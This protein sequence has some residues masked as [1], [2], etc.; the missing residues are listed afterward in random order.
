M[1]HRS[2]SFIVTLVLA[3][4]FLT[5][6]SKPDLYDSEGGGISLKDDSGKWL[7]LNIWAE[8]CDPCRDEVPELNE[9]ADSGTVR[10]LG[11]DFDN[12]QGDELKKKIKALDIRFPVVSSS[13]LNLL[14]TQVPAVLPAT[15]IV[16]AQGKLV[17]VLYGPQTQSGLKAKFQELQDRKEGKG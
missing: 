13:P 3:T 1:M 14:N 8:W 17:E 2:F 11:F 12:A 15:L 6:C 4:I 16:D 9:L 10:V 7:A 5:G